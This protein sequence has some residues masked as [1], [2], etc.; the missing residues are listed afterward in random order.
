M[1]T[2][3]AIKM[4]Y[5]KELLSYINE[6]VNQYPLFKGEQLRRRIVEEG[7]SPEVMVQWHKSVLLE[8]FPDTRSEV[9]ESFGFLLN[10]MEEYQ[11]AYREALSLRYLQKEFRTE[12]EIAANMQNTLL[13]TK[14]PTIPELEIGAISIPAKHMNG[15][16]YHFVQDDNGCIGFGIADVI[17]NGIPAALCMSMIKYAM[18]SIQESH[19]LPSGILKALNRVVEQNV[20]DSMFISMFYGL[21]NPLTNC[22]SYASAG[23]EPGIYYDAAKG[24]FEE[25]YAKGLLLGV[26]KNTEYIQMEKQVQIGDVIILMTDGVTECR[27]EEG[28]IERGY[29]IDS[30]R[31][32]I[33]LHPRQIVVNVFKHLE[34]LQHF[35]LRDDFTLII[36]KR[37]A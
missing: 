10:M 33:H 34:R 28:F 32:H 15:D 36:L 17:G 13:E 37:K 9:L 30:I 21:Y 14:I 8:S 23:H 2:R 22:L 19:H 5:R 31:Q 29:L 20:D 25:L 26:D 1:S 16:Y 18:D 12:M 4:D 27:T 35:Q 24:Q 7:I 3:E 11:E 6:P